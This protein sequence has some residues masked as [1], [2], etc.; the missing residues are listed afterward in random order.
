MKKLTV[1]FLFAFLSVAAF[2]QL[3]VVAAHDGQKFD[4]QFPAGNDVEYKVVM[5][6]PINP[7]VLELKAGRL[8]ANT[9]TMS[10]N[11]DADLRYIYEVRYRYQMANGELSEW[12]MVDP[13]SLL[14]AEEK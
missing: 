5:V 10:V 7:G 6:D 4:V 1:F 14:N 13:K 12:F 3:Q 11:W 9:A 2:A 8:D